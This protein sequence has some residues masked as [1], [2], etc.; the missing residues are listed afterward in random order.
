[1]SSQLQ[2]SLVTPKGSVFEGSGSQVVAP[3]VAGQLTI[4]PLH[5]ALLCCLAPGRLEIGSGAGATR[6][7][8]GGGFLEVQADKI[9]ILVDSAVPA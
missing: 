1:V 9:S 3:S 5:T 7:Q 6:L 4:L 8:V 2:I